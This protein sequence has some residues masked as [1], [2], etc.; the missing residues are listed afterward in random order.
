M[1]KTGERV[2]DY[3]EE[4]GLEVVWVS[5]RDGTRLR[6]L[7][8][9]SQDAPRLLCV[10]GF[11]QN[12]AEWRGLLPR[13]RDRF[14]VLM[15][16][17]RGY[18]G[19]DL[20]ASGDYRLPTLADDLVCVLES[21]A[22]GGQRGPAHLVAHDWGAVVAWALVEARPDLV[23]HHVSVNGPHYGAYT[24]E[25]NANREQ[26]KSSWYT[27]FFQL[28]LVERFL[29]RDGAVALVRSLRGTSARGT[30]SDEDLE[31]YVGPLRDPRRMRAAL[32][33]Y[34]ASFP[35]AL[36]ALVRRGAAPSGSGRE[37]VRVPTIIVW[38]A[39]DTAIRVGVAQRMLR[40]VCPDAEL[41]L[42]EEASHWVPD[43]RP[44]AVA[45]AV[46]DG[47]GRAGGARKE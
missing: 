1:A 24:R 14:R 18:A 10:H 7:C 34:R 41:R 2:L 39:K 16:D 6:V 44:D 20:A 28:P 22:T 43:E 17:L 27:V 9:G 42:L 25:V 4:H 15:V 35:A 45:E 37:P 3:P 40:E 23:A 13:V 21:P 5:V 30:F 12:A 8:A 26:L 33:Y 31:L 47:L 19:S 32:S 46:L 36:R 38:G 29:A 11:P